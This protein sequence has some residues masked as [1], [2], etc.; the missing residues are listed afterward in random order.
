[1]RPLDFPDFIQQLVGMFE[2]QARQKGLDFHY[3]PDGP[4]PEMVRADER[5]LRQILLNILGNAVKFT[6]SGS[7][8]LRLRYQREMA[9]FSIEDTGPGIA[10]EEV[11]NIFEPFS[12]GSAA[13]VGATG[14]TGLGLTIASMLTDLMGG[15]LSVTGTP[16]QGSR[17][18]V[19]LFLPS[20]HAEQLVKEP[21]LAPRIGYVGVRRRILVVD[22]EQVERELLVNILEPLGFHV[23]QASSGPQ[24]LEEIPRCA[25]H[26][27]F[28]D[29]AMPGMDG[30]ETLRRIRA[31]GLA[32]AQIA[33]ISANAFEK[34]A[35]NDAGISSEDFITKPF[36]VDE[37]LDWLGK[38][39]N[40]EWVR[41]G[42][43]RPGRAVRRH[44][45]PAHHAPRSRAH[46]GAPGA[47]RSRLPAGHPEKARRDRNP[48]PRSM[49]SSSA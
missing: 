29:L 8:T 10:P 25:P 49:P 22:N 41:A 45:G 1:M 48:G 15:E 40:L 33:I 17:F 2:Q 39:L 38:R 9:F 21:P 19:R 5:R 20:I 18:D 6:V 14:G 47:D 31:G 43:S 28:M 16:G 4:L 37:L 12:R 46:D 13:H 24:C 26:V 7:V 23:T 3:L 11:G 35:E 32:H 42:P 36:S 30:W 44:P 27:I 34:G